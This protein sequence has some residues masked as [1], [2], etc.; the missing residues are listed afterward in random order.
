MC[1]NVLYIYNIYMH[2]VSLHIII[3]IDSLHIFS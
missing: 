3:L 2:Y 1:D